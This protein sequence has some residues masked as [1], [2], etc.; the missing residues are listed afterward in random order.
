MLTGSRRDISSTPLTRRARGGL[1]F[2][3]RLARAC[4][5]RDAAK[6]DEADLMILER[7]HLCVIP[8]VCRSAGSSE[9][10]RGGSL[11]EVLGVGARATDDGQPLEFGS[12]RRD[13]PPDSAIALGPGGLA[14]LVTIM[15]VRHDGG[16]VLAA[17]AE[18]W[19][20]SCRSGNRGPGICRDQRSRR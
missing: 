5:Q 11:H 18:E 12:G 14:N 1:V 13:G 3:G 9:P 19:A 8:V 10:G 17:L 6:A 7:M 2:A 15:P 20:S 4:P 16:A